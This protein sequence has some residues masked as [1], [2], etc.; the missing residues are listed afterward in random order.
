MIDYQISHQIIHL[1]TAITA[2]GPRR[3]ANN[4]SETIGSDRGIN[5][6][7]KIGVSLCEPPTPRDKAIDATVKTSDSVS[8]SV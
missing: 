2:P 3:D 5:L 6:R 1:I 8:F 7:E 4:S